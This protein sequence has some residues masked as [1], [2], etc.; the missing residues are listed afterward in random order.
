MC[1]IAYNNIYLSFN[2]LFQFVDLGMVTSIEYNHKSVESA[3]KGQEVCIKIEPVP[4]EAPKMFGRHFEAKDFLVSKVSVLIIGLPINLFTLNTRRNY[5]IRLYNLKEKF[6]TFS[7]IRM[8]E[9]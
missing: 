7:R 2:L 6:S 1:N 4:G 3:R 5:K 9:E 8:I